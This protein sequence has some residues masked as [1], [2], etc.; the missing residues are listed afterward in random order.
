MSSL[1]YMQVLILHALFGLSKY[2]VLCPDVYEV[3]LNSKLKK[4]AGRQCRRSTI[5]LGPIV[6]PGH[7]WK[8]PRKG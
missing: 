6:F 3:P 8:N 2:R 1:M 5:D 7:P 4:E